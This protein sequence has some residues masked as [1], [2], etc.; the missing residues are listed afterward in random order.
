MIILMTA[1]DIENNL[2]VT[3]LLITKLINEENSWC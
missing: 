1:V 2:C 3:F